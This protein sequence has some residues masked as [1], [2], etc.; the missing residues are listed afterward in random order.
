VR[1]TKCGGAI[2]CGD[3]CWDQRGLQ[4]R[5]RCNKPGCSSGR[6]LHFH[7]STACYWR[8]RRARLRKSPRPRKCASCRKPFTPQRADARTCSSRC[9]QALYRS[10]R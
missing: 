5:W 4:R 10:R 7:C 2:H 6:L 1:C 9:R 8:D 3:L